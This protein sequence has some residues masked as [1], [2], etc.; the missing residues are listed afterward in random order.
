MFFFKK[1]YYSTTKYY[2]EKYIQKMP[3]FL[4]FYHNIIIFILVNNRYITFWNKKMKNKKAFTLVELIVVITI[5]AILATVGF[6]SFS[7]YLAWARD[8]NRIAQLKSMSDAL[9]LYRTKKDLPIPDDKID[10]QRSWETTAYQWYIGANVL[11]TIEYTEKWLDPKDKTYFTYLL[12]KDKKEYQ[13]MSFLEEELEDQVAFDSSFFNKSTAAD[14]SERF[15]KTLWKKVWILLDEDNTPAQDISSVTSDWFLDIVSTDDTYQMVFSDSNIIT[16]TWNVI[17]SWK[18]WNWL[19][20]YWDFDTV[21][22]VVANITSSWTW[23]NDLEAGVTL[24]PWKKWNSIHLSGTRSSSGFLLDWNYSPEDFRNWFTFSAWIKRDV[25]WPVF[26]TPIF[27]MLWHELWAWRIQTCF[28]PYDNHNQNLTSSQLSEDE[29]YFYHYNE[30]ET[31]EMPIDWSYH[32]YTIA[33]DKW[34]SKLYRDWKLVYNKDL[35]NIQKVYFANNRNYYTWIEEENLI[36]T[37]NWNKL[38]TSENRVNW[39]SNAYDYEKSMPFEWFNINLGVLWRFEWAIDELRIYD[40]ILTDEEVK[41]L[42]EM[43]K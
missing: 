37:Q 13:L 20:G 19:V 29:A 8:T 2:T 31:W 25:K 34:T 39:Y 28:I 43:D 23:S 40:R 24:E 17:Q 6:V 5:L 33:F 35:W 38:S 41:D 42:Y 4:Y 18:L 1:K 30:V 22:K 16:W 36:W 21:D 15:P 26:S 14:L 32:L 7:W 10:I 9:E 12:T 27:R 11:E 3:I